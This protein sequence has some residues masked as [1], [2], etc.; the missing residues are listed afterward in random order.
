MVRATGA[1]ALDQLVGDGLVSE[2]ARPGDARLAGIPGEDRH[3]GD[4]D[5][6]QAQVG[7][8]EDDVGDFP[9]SSKCSGRSTGAD[10]PTMT[11]AV[12]VEPVKLIRPTW[13]AHQGVAGL[14]AKARHH[15]H[16]SRGQSGLEGQLSQP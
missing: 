2:D 1:D 9:P 13:M 6:R 10:R 14:F 16:H 7:I 4:P 12:S 8:G 15:V 5:T 11:R 3:R